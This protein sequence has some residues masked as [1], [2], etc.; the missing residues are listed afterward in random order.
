M[1]DYMFSQFLGKK[2]SVKVWNRIIVKGV[3]IAHQSSNTFGHLP[4]MLVLKS[5]D[6]FLLLREWEVLSVG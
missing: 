4:D 2:V 1:A 3:L 5:D 6:G